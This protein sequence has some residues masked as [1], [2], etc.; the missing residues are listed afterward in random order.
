MDEGCG[1]VRTVALGRVV[2]FEVRSH[3]HLKHLSSMRNDSFAGVGGRSNNAICCLSGA[4]LHQL[5]DI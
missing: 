3:Q 2:L 4:E 5:T 1:N